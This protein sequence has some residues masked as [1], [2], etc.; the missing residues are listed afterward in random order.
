[1]NHLIESLRWS[2]VWSMQWIRRSSSSQPQSSQPYQE[3]Y[4]Q[5]YVWP[6]VH[7]SI[8]PQQ[9][10]IPIT[11][12]VGVG[13]DSKPRCPSGLLIKLLFTWL[14][15][16][17]HSVTMEPARRL[18]YSITVL[19]DCF[20]CVG[21]LLLRTYESPCLDS[22]LLKWEGEFCRFM[23]SPTDQYRHCSK[24][25][26]CPHRPLVYDSSALVL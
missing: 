3:R 23:V 15:A 10:H 8:V 22:I 11:V 19:I 20:V 12:V 5:V 2:F 21:L 16:L 1:M 4:D 9:P 24:P 26:A 25:E 14:W 18:R 13:V 17:R 7:V 6:R